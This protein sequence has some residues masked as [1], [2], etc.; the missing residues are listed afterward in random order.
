MREI[1]GKIH[2]LCPTFDPCMISGECNGNCKGDFFTDNTATDPIPIPYCTCL[3]STDVKECDLSDESDEAIAFAQ[4]LM[5]NLAGSGTFDINLQDVE[6]EC[7]ELP[8]CGKDKK[9]SCEFKDMV[10][11]CVMPDGTPCS[12]QKK[13]APTPDTFENTCTINPGQVFIEERE[14][15]QEASQGNFQGDVGEEAKKRACEKSLAC[16]GDTACQYVNGV[17]GCFSVTEPI[18]EYDIDDP[19][20]TGEWDE[21]TVTPDG[22]VVVRNCNAGDTCEP[23]EM[24]S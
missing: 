2:A 20:A 24:G 7:T 14:I 22:E 5:N 12:D 11:K 13:A 19:M 8:Q 6:D 21:G 9:G 15:M 23:G 4:N 18:E 17:C 10:C 16:P 3:G 1:E